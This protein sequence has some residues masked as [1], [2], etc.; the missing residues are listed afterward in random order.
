MS[1][2]KIT[3]ITRGDSKQNQ[4]I[5]DKIKSTCTNIEIL[6]AP[7]FYDMNVFNK[8][9]ENA[10]LLITLECWKDIHPAFKTI[11]LITNERMPYGILYSKSPSDDALKFL[12]IIK[13]RENKFFL[14]FI[15]KI[16]YFFSFD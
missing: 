12:D 3:A 9:E 16:N 15:N 5:L 4:D 6:E 1:N 7:F 13:N 14:F 2:E 11:P 8:C 10:S